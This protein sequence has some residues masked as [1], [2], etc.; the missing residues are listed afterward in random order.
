M[1][2][3]IFGTGDYSFSGHRGNFPQS[4]RFGP[5]DNYDCRRQVKSVSHGNKASTG[6]FNVL[7]SEIPETSY[8]K[9][10]K[11]DFSKKSWVNQSEK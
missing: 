5:V 1:S 6:R 4:G 2:S 8:R 3:Y 11:W 10:M 7:L 9:G